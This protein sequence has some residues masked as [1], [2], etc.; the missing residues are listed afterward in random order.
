MADIARSL[1][2]A[3]PVVREILLRHGGVSPRRRRQRDTALT[4]VEREE[5]SRGLVRGWSLRRIALLIQRAPSTVSR[6]V[7]RNGGPQCYR[8]DAAGIRARIQEARPK[9][10]KLSLNP[11]LRRIVATKLKRFWSPEQIA[12]WLKVEYRNQ[13]PMQVSHETIYQSLFVQTRGL[14]K[15]ELIECLRSGRRMRRAKVSKRSEKRGVLS[16]FVSIRQRPAEVDDRAVPGHWEGDLIVGTHTN[17]IATLVERKSRFVLLVKVPSKETVPV[18]EALIK[19]VRKLPDELRRSLTWDR[20]HELC[21][22]KRFTLATDMKVY[23][24]DPQSPWQRGTNENTNALLR[25]YFPKGQSVAH[26]TQAQLNRVARELNERPRK[27]LGFQT[28]AYALDQAL[29]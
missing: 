11:R 7:R 27:T 2:R 18:V 12:A 10:C 13:P 14:L 4:A 3:E 16:D 22:H 20:G 19:Q 15:A 1:E 28:P 5:V 26:Y 24:C 29:R 8:A 9:R 23:F 6:E 17:F 25:Q 21:Q